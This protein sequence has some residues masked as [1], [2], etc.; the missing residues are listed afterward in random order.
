MFSDI[1]N[2]ICMCVGMVA[3]FLLYYCYLLYFCQFASRGESTKKEPDEDD[4]GIYDN[5]SDDM[6]EYNGTE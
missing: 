2:E 1:I 6:G 3:W 5:V 4:P